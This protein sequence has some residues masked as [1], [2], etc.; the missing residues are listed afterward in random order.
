MALKVFKK[1]YMTPIALESAY[2]ERSI[3]EKFEHANILKLKDFYEDTDYM[4]LVC[5]LMSSD[6]RGVLQE[7][8]SKLAEN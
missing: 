7:L 6:I 1:K 2:L 5:E 8:V 4:I 3:M